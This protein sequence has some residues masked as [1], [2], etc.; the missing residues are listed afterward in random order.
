MTAL[1]DAPARPAEPP[2][3]H[4]PPVVVAAG[5]LVLFGGLFFFAVTRSELWLDEALS[6][7]RVDGY[8]SHLARRSEI[9]GRR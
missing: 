8:E 5:I 9:G 2:D 3:Q 1:S 7:I 6:V 4:L